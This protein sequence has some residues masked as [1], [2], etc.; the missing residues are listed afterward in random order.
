MAWFSGSEQAL[1]GLTPQGGNVFR[2]GQGPTHQAKAESG[3]S[4]CLGHADKIGNRDK[5]AAPHFVEQLEQT[6]WHIVA[7]AHEQLG[8][9]PAR[10][11]KAVG[12]GRAGVR[13]IF[14][15]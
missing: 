12:A 8:L 10:G 15:F 6:G 13:S 14:M 9:D 1:R 3:P 5:P 7:E 11:I 2:R 4:V